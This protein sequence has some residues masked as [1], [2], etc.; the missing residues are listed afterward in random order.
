MKIIFFFKGLMWVKVEGIR[1]V[2]KKNECLLLLL[3]R[4]LLFMGYL[5][6]YVLRVWYVLFNLIFIIWRGIVC[7]FFIFWIGVGGIERVVCLE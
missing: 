3:V 7:D 2:G 6:L 5:L 1:W 4:Y